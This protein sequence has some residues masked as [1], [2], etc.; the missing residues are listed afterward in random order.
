MKQKTVEIMEAISEKI[1]LPSDILAGAP[2]LSMAGQ[3][4]LLIENYKGI[5]EYTE[6]L[7]RVQTKTGRIHV[8]GKNLNIEYYTADDM[9]ITGYITAVQFCD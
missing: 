9:K 8:E 3:R 2:L 5:I 6:E 7:I 1:K 4:Q